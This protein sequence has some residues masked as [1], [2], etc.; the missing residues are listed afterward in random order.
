MCA[1]AFEHTSEAVSRCREPYY[2]TWWI[3]SSSRGLGSCSPSKTKNTDMTVI[4][5]MLQ[6]I[7][8]GMNELKQDFNSGAIS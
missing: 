2:A 4:I 7:E 5:K 6:E 8:Y 1:E 3:E